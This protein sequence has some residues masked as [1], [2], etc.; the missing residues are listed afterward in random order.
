MTKPPKFYR[1]SPTFRHTIDNEFI[2]YQRTGPWVIEKKD[3]TEIC[4]AT[5]FK[6]LKEIFAVWWQANG[7]D[8]R[9]REYGRF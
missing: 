4:R 8:K 6:Y 2:A 3:G 9:E 7:Y 5:S 1:G